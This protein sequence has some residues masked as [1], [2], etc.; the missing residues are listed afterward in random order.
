MK[1]LKYI[2]LLT[3]MVGF[4]SSCKDDDPVEEPVVQVDPF[5]IKIEG[6]E[7]VAS[8]T[9]VKTYNVVGDAG[10]MGFNITN[11]TN[12]SIDLRMTVVGVTGGGEGMQLCFTTCS[13]NINLN[14]TEIK[15]INAGQT[16]TNVQTHIYNGQV[17]DRDFECTIKI[18]QVD[19]NGSDIPSG[20][21]LNFTYKYVAP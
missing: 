3:L 17:G 5:I 19:S 13:A 20:K 8:A 7:V 12:A 9:T 18:N 21:E 10:E 2:L 11:K 4:L 6:E 16:T 1:N 14:D 15:T